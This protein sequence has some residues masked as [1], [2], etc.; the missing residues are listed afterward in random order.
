MHILCMHK[1]IK[2][3]KKPGNAGSVGFQEGQRNF[4]SG[5]VEVIVFFL[6]FSD[7]ELALEFHGGG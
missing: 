4:Q 7:N 5:S 2:K 3:Q 1:N 6:K